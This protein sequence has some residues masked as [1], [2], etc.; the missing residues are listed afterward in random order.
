MLARDRATQTEATPAAERNKTQKSNRCVV[1]PRPTEFFLKYKSYNREN[2]SKHF[3]CTS[4][5]LLRTEKNEATPVFFFLLTFGSRKLPPRPL[6]PPP[7]LPPPVPCFAAHIQCPF[8]LTKMGQIIALSSNEKIQVLYVREKFG[9]TNQIT[10]GSLVRNNW[11]ALRH[12]L[13]S[14]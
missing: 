4:S 1:I 9:P 6:P 10:A 11:I 7:P 14:S 5:L 3:F 12:T 2:V 13:P 8:C